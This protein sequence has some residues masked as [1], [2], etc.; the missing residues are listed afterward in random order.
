MPGVVSC[1]EEIAGRY[2]HGSCRRQQRSGMG[3]RWILRRAAS[4]ASC[5]ELLVDCRKPGAL[6]LDDTGLHA[7]IGPCYRN[8]A[9]RKHRWRRSL[10]FGRIRTDFRLVRRASAKVKTTRA[11]GNPAGTARTCHRCTTAISSITGTRHA[12]DRPRGGAGLFAHFIPVTVV[13][14]Y[15]DELNLVFCRHD[16]TS[17]APPCP[18][19]ASEDADCGKNERGRPE[20]PPY[21]EQSN[22]RRIERVPTRRR[23]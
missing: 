21:I 5:T 2:S 1:D 13:E 14:P 11:K 7:R 17:T 4:L 9:E 20:R 22:L 15:Q 23:F 19:C 3:L 12:T 6:E 10:R 16:G 8:R 18:G